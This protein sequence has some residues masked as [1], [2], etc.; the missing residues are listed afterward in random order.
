MEGKSITQM[1]RCFNQCLTIAFTIFKRLKCKSGHVEY[2]FDKTAEN[3]F[4]EKIQYFPLRFGKT[5]IFFFQKKIPEKVPLDQSHKITV[6]VL[7]CQNG[8][9]YSKYSSGHAECSFDNPAE[10]SL[11]NIRSK[12]ENIFEKLFFFQKRSFSPK[13]SSRRK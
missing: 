11:K 10:R 4:C 2:N 13:T 3:F 6:K 9:F 1:L 5:V 8:K 12:S 7:F